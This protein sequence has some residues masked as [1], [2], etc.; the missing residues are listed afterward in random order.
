MYKE[1]QQQL[2]SFIGK[3]GTLALLKYL[4]NFQNLKESDLKE[5]ENIITNVS[6]LY[7]VEVKQ[8]QNIKNQKT[9]IVDARRLIT[10]FLLVN[11]N[12]EVKFLSNWLNCSKRTIYKYKEEAIFRKQ[13][14]KIFK[15]FNQ[16][17]N[18]F[19]HE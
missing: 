4:S 11:K 15:V 3:F 5:F 7:N 19:T 9:S 6:K 8:I 12:Y 14:P 2:D 1:L 13:N 10:Y 17:L 18:Q 16:N